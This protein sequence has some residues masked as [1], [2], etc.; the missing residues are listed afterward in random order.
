MMNC[1]GAIDVSLG[2]K[3][4]GHSSIKIFGGTNIVFPY[5]FHGIGC[6]KFL[7]TF[8]LRI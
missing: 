6:T 8:Q 7:V 2:Y 3:H 4:V 1:S 5:N